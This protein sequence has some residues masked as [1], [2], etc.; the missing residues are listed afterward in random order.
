MRARKLSIE[1]K[2]KKEEGEDQA[3]H[4]AKTACYQMTKTSVLGYKTP[5]L[6]TILVCSSALE[7]CSRTSQVQVWHR[8]IPQEKM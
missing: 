3:G 2:E 6:C 5:V 7:M 1:E 4:I 8:P